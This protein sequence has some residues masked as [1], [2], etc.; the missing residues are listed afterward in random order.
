MKTLPP[1]CGDAEMRRQR[2][3]IRSWLH[4]AADDA[5]LDIYAGK[6]LT[7]RFGWNCAMELQAD[8]GRHFIYA[9]DICPTSIAVVCKAVIKPGTIVALRR[10]EPEP[11][12][13]ARVVQITETLGGF[14]TGLIFVAGPDWD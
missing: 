14:R 6:R 8:D 2:A 3:Q 1:N 5:T 12:V 4:I 10:D 7:P 13:Q 9:E 11:W